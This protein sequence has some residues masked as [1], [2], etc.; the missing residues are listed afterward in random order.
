MPSTFAASRGSSRL[1][2]FMASGLV[3]YIYAIPD[4]PVNVSGNRPPYPASVPQLSAHG[5]Q[6][7]I[8]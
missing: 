8:A 4:S 2:R 6:L 3:R 1:V 7:A 5:I